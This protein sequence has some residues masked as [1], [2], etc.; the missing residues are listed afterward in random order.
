M[1]DSTR[2]STEA[3]T[4]LFLFAHPRTRSNLFIRLL[5][6]HPQMM[7][8]QYPF[9]MGFMRGPESQWPDNIKEAI[10]RTLGET[11]ESAEEKYANLT[12]QAGLDDM[13]IF[14]AEAEAKVGGQM[15]PLES[16]GSQVDIVGKILRG[17]RAHSLGVQVEAG[18]LLRQ[19]FS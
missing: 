16:Y 1:V 10:F 3:H 13:E 19:F 2:G 7:C 15:L 14:L 18:K 12:Y 4:R 9:M 8:K 17:Q 6:T 11:K 5:E